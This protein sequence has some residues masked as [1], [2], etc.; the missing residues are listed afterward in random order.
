MAERLSP[1]QIAAREK[2]L[3]QRH[4]VLREQVQHALSESGESDLQ[5]VAGRVRDSG[6]D[7]VADLISGL[8]FHRIDHLAREISA[9]EHA[10]AR[11]REGS[12]GYC[13]DCGNPIDPARLRVLPSASRCIQCQGR[14]EAE[15]KRSATP[16]L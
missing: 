4:Q 11:I 13:D 8:N 7:S 9:V 15:Y 10:L 6:E 2:E 3:R 14:Y 12:Y 1:S 16:S 5:A